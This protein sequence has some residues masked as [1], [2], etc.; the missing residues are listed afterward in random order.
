MNVEHVPRSTP[1][2]DWV[3]ARRRQI[4]DQIRAARLHANLTQEAVAHA[5]P[6]DRAT[7]VRI[8][9]GQSAATLDTLLLVAGVIRVPLAQLVR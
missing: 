3:L 9:Q 2:P 6:M 5:V 4:G 1:P 7:Y 8:E